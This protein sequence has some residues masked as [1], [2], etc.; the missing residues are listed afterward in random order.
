ML[1]T[2]LD[3]SKSPVYAASWSRA[4]DMVTYATGKSIHIKPLQPVRQRRA[5][6][7]RA[8]P[9]AECPP[10]GRA[11]ARGRAA[12]HHRTR[13]AHAA[14]PP[15]RLSPLPQAAKGETWKAHEGI[16]LAVDWNEVN[17]KIVSGSEDR[18]YKVWNSYG[19]ILYSR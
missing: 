2:V 6:P 5:S 17:E 15:P 18:K 10:R 19:Q 12:R 11:A 1:R 7:P 13:A 8:R 3:T 9:T 4:S 16:V 14:L